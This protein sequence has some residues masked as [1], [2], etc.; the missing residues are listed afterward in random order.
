[1]SDAVTVELEGLP[2]VTIGHT[3][4]EGAAHVHAKAR[5]LPDIPLLML[6]PPAAGVVGE[7]AEASDEQMETI[8]RALTREPP[9]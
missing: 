1:V 9:A 6:E 2:T 8:V 3:T 5:G 7:A 4:F